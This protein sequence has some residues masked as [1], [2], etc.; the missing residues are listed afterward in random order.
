MI[1]L[2]FCCISINSQQKCRESYLAR[3]S[4]VLI[5]IHMRVLLVCLLCSLSSCWMFRAFKVRK[6]Q[7][8]DHRKL[9]SVPIAKSDHPYYFRKTDDKIKYS[10]VDLIDSLLRNTETAAFLVIRND[11]LLYEKYFLGFDE[12]SILPSNSMAKSFTGTLVAIALYEGKIKSVNEP[13]T[14]YLPELGKRDARFHKITIQHLLDM[15]SGLDFNEGAYNLND[16][17][18]QLGFRR[19]LVK[20]L[21]RAKIKEEPGKFKY[22]SINPQLLGLIV[23]RATGEK[24][25][26]YFQEKLWKP[27]GAE[28]DATWNVDSRKRKHVLTSAAI[29]ATAHDFAKLGRLYLQK[30]RL[31]DKQLIST[32]WIKTVAS[33]DTLE[34]YQGYKNQWWNK[35]GTQYYKDSVVK[36]KKMTPRKKRQ[37]VLRRTDRGYFLNVPTE[38]FNAFGFLEQIIYINPQ[39]N[40]IIVRLGREWPHEKFTQTIYDLGE[41]L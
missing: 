37:V 32:D 13:I 15:R 25:Q 7:L 26:Y 20:H 2:Y 23:E 34:K 1:G 10:N 38:A 9:P 22:Q 6:L 3:S 33:A 16:D 19:N 27:L 29:N 4:S 17:A 24:L 11:S 14:N 30:G 28:N 18:V 35:R 36:I 40:L 39:K 21:L 5:K 8:T 41:R 12:N 31:S